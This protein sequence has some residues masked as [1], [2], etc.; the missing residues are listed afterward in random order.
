[1][2]WMDFLP[3]DVRKKVEDLQTEREV[4]VCMAMASMMAKD[5]YRAR[6]I[7]ARCNKEIERLVT[8]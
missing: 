4:A 1:M 8:A 6:A 7:I 2:T 5:K 3:D